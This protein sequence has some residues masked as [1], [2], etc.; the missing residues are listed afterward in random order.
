[1]FVP[2]GFFVGIFKRYFFCRCCLSV[3]I[4]TAGGRVCLPV[5]GSST[6]ENGGR[7]TR[8]PGTISGTVV[9]TSR[10]EKF[11]LP[12]QGYRRGVVVFLLG[13]RILIGDGRCTKAILRTN[14]FVLRTVN[15]GCR[16]LTVA[17]IRYIYCQFDGPRFFYRSQCGRVVGR[18]APPLVFCPLAVAPRLRLFLRDSGTCL[19]RRGVYQ[20]VLYFGQGRLTF[21]LK[22]CCSSCRLSVLVRPLTRCA[23]SFRCFILRGRTGIGAMRRLTRLKKCAMTA[24]QHVFGSIFRRPIC[25]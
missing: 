23:G 1:M 21:V 3:F 8:Y 15:S 2:Q 24:F 11:R 19:S 4:A 6:Y 9:C 5:P 13:K 7:Y 10:P 16:V 18:I 25:R 17:S 22:G 20:R 12:T 14:R